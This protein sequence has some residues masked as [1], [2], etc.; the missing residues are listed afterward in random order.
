MAWPWAFNKAVS[1][2]RQVV[3]RVQRLVVNPVTTLET[4]GRGG[5]LLTIRVDLD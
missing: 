2:K 1:L 3:R 4:T 5:D